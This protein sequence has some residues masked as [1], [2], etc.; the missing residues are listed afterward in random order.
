MAERKEDGGAANARPPMTAPRTGHITLKLT[1]RQA[2]ILWAIL[3]GQADA[4]ACE[5]G[6]RPEE[7][8]AIA[9]MT[10]KLNAQIDKW[11]AKR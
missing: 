3:D 2:R 7:A 6:N 11:S 5:G 10:G 8:R 4:G 1:P 9:S